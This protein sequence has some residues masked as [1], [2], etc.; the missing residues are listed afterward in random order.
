MISLNNLPGIVALTAILAGTLGS[1]APVPNPQFGVG[2]FSLPL[3]FLGNGRGTSIFGRAEQDRNAGGSLICGVL[4]G[5]G[6]RGPLSGLLRLG[7]RLFGDIVSPEGIHGH[8]LQRAEEDKNAEDLSM[9]LGGGGGSGPNPVT[10]FDVFDKF[11]NK[12]HFLGP[13]SRRAEE[14]KNDEDLSI[15]GIIGGVLGP[16]GLL[17]GVVGGI[18]GPGGVVDGVVGPDGFLHDLLGRECGGGGLL[19]GIISRAEQDRN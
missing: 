12:R 13:N 2:R 8:M 6:G 10:D 7:D 11:C 15:P 1:T 14:D 19:E 17:G 18:L 3:G 9:L 5:C 16:D 4:G